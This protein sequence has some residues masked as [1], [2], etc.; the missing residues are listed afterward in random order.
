M[1]AAKRSPIATFK[2]DRE[3]RIQVLRESS[4][5]FVIDNQRRAAS[6]WRRHV[7][8]AP[9]YDPTKE[10]MVALALD[11][12]HQIIGHYLISIGTLSACVW[13][14]REVFRIAII[15]GSASVILM[16][17]H[18][19]GV[20]S[21]SESDLDATRQLLRAG[22]LLKIELLDHVIIGRRPYS[23]RRNSDLPFRKEPA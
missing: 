1:T 6:Y 7:T 10:M 19:S 8:N 3:M 4:R 22:E 15:V 23:L 13:H 17:N 21:P 5:P 16:H 20:S 14:A 2:L 11:G 12:R 18:P 9:W